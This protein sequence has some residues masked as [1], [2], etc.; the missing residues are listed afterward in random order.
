MSA[1]PAILALFQN[2]PSGGISNPA[3]GDPFSINTKQAIRKSISKMIRQE[4]ESSRSY[5]LADLWIFVD[6]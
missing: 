4:D 6:L 3:S 5:S 1:N 2:N